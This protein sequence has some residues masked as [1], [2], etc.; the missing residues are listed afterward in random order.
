MDMNTGLGANNPMPS[1]RPAPQPTTPM[2][3]QAYQNM[4]RAHIIGEKSETLQA[5]LRGGPV[6]AG[7]DV[8]SMPARPENLAY[9]LSATND[10]LAAVESILDALN[11]EFA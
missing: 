3:E 5:R 11:N 7:R 9:T 1:T 10:A 4:C 8:G 2:G 6:M